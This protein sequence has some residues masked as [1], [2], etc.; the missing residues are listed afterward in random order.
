MASEPQDLAS[1]LWQCPQ[2]QI[3]PFGLESL[4]VVLAE[5]FFDRILD[6]LTTVRMLIHFP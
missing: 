6:E 3:N 4:L 2:V 5:L 1:S